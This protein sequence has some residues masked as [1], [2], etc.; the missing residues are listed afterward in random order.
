MVSLSNRS[1]VPLKGPKHDQVGYEI[2][3]IKQTR[4]VRGLGGLAK[5]IIFI[6]IWGRYAP[7]C[8]FNEC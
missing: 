1:D 2:F 3:Y 7:F 6:F 8:I 5:K 4:M